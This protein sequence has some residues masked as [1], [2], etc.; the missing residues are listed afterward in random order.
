MYLIEDVCDWGYNNNNILNRGPTTCIL[1]TTQKQDNAYYNS[2]YKS[3]NAHNSEKN[4]QTKNIDI[5]LS[6]HDTILE[7]S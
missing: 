5:K 1:I 6:A 7:Y 2:S 3:R 4:K